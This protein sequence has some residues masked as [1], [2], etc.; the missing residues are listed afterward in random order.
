[1]WSGDM[2]ARV[3]VVLIVAA[4]TFLAGCGGSSSS[5]SGRPRNGLE[6]LSADEIAAKVT[7]TMEGVSSFRF[8]GAAGKG[9]TTFQYDLQYAG[10]DVKGL[11][12][13]N[14]VTFEVIVVDDAQY[15][16]GSDDYW[17]SLLP[18]DKEAAILPQLSGK[19]VRRGDK[20]Y[21]IIPKAKD[22]ITISG[23]LT[24]GEESTI[25]GTPV[26]SIS[27]GER[28][29]R[30]ALVGEPYLMESVTERGTVEFLDVNGGKTVSPP[31][32]DSTVDL[33][34]LDASIC[35]S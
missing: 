31:S 35:A 2:R 10:S 16:R 26:I 7:E 13:A 4:T 30:A 32:D 19:F 9:A 33:C 14:G 34:E 22:I 20:P 24:K 15:L 23:N 5:G 21:D 12:T 1:L 28:T 18:D 25:K 8:K 3:L 6:D 11:V 17:K 27:D 29:L